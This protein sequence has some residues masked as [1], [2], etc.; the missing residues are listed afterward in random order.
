MLNFKESNR[1]STAD[2]AAVKEQFEK[3]GYLVEKLDKPKSKQRRPDF[4][5]SNSSGCR[6]LLC[7]VK[8]VDSAWY[9]RDESVYGVKDVHISTLDDKFRGRYQNI[10]IDLRKIDNRL[11]DAVDKRKAL[12]QHD[13][14]FADLPLLVAFF[15]DFYVAELLFA[16]PRTFGK[17][18]QT[19]GDE[20]PL[21]K[22]FPD[23]TGILWIKEDVARMRAWKELSD[24]E[25]RRRV[26][27]RSTNDD[28]P[29]RSKD[30]VLIKNNAALRVVPED[31]ERVCLP[32]DDEYYYR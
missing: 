30:F 25:Q 16:Y 3:L 1:R 6:Q 10:P 2:E 21:H 22:Y 12:V 9:P 20:L 31:F 18:S 7:E 29:P 23:V 4:L 14:S 17:H 32:D 28:L 8:R 5:I 13:S 19:P 27:T 15:L 26:E 24:E 11:A